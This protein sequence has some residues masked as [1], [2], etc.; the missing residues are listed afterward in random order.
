[1]SSAL[2]H[3]LHVMPNGVI[4][5]VALLNAFIAL[6][7]Y[8]AAAALVDKPSVGR[9]KLQQYGFLVTG[10]LF[11]LCGY[12]RDQLS[13]F[14]LVVMYFGSSFFG[15]CGPNCTTFLIPAEIFPTEMRTMCHGISAA[16]GKLGALTAAIMF[17]YLTESGMFLVSGYCSFL[18]CLVTFL[19]IPESS[20][21]DLHELDK[22]WILTLSGRMDEYRGDANDFRHMSTWE[23]CT[24]N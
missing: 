4:F 24:M 3:V 10:T 2:Q 5:L 7:G 20:T 16:A 23:R 12:L 18:A 6:I 15:Q 1:M 17:N 9:L 11:C 8:Y 14:W 22:K 13:T 19:T 21:L